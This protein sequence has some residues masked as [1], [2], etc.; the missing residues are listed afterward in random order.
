MDSTDLT[1]H[2][3]STVRKQRLLIHPFIHTDGGLL[4]SKF[5]PIRVKSLAQGHNDG[6][7]WS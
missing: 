3:S 7:G 1:D 4:P 5:L 2:F 6:S